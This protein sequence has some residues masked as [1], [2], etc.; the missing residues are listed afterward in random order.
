MSSHLRNSLVVF[1]VAVVAFGGLASARAEGLYV[2]GSLGAPDY[3][4]SID[5]VGGGGGGAGPG[6]ELYGG[7]ELTPN[8]ALEGGYFDLG[9]SSDV[10]GTARA[11]GLYVDAIGGVMLVPDWSLQARL[12]VAEGRLRTSLGDDNSPAIKLGLGVQYDL[13]KNTA[14]RLGYEHYRFTDA[15]GSRPDVG[16]TSLGLKFRF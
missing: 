6:L 10:G 5:G 16:Q 7:Y 12:G 11:R 15:F 1:A 4:S 8:F 13:S 2:G 9:R 3:R 14:L